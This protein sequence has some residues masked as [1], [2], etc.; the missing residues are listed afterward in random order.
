[1]SEVWYRRA[2]QESHGCIVVR[3]AHMARLH[4]QWRW[5]AAMHLVGEL[6]ILRMEPLTAVTPLSFRSTLR[7]TYVGI[8]FLPQ[9]A[10][11]W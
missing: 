4:T 10:P 8:H 3:Q 9:F 7:T 11:C 6:A 5:T 1:M 2:D